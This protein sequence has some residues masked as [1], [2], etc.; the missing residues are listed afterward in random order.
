M[1]TI[2]S[3]VAGRSKNIETLIAGHLLQGI[4]SGGILV[5]TKIIICNLLPLRERGKYLGLIVSLVRLAAALGPFFVGGGLR[6]GS[7]CNI[8][9]GRGSFTSI[10]PSVA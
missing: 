3:G 2:G 4:G 7:W 1:F 10:S 6:V 5:L 9:H 8:L